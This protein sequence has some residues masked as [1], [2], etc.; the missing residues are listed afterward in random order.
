MAY[1]HCQTRIR[2]RTLILVLYKYYGKGIQIWIRVCIIPC[3]HRVWN[4]SPSLNLNPSLAVE[5]SHNGSFTLPEMDSG[6]DWDSDSCPVQ[7]QGVGIR[8]RVCAMW[9]VLHSKMLCNHRVWNPNPSPSPAMQMSHQV[10][11]T[12]YGF[13][14]IKKCSLHR[15]VLISFHFFWYKPSFT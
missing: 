5:I 6:T 13:P 7:D 14:V 9:N 12:F 4:P 1:F 3:S 10:L 8:V 2:T 15:F 11:D